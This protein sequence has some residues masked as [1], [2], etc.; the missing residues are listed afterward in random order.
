MDFEKYK[1]I[2]AI[3]FSTLKHIFRSY[4]S[5]LYQKDLITETTDACLLG[6][7]LHEKILENIDII[8]EN[9]ISIVGKRGGIL[10][11]AEALLD[12]YYGVTK[13]APLYDFS[14]MTVEQSYTFTYKDL[15]FKCRIDAYDADT[16]TLVDLKSTRKYVGFNYEFKKMYYDMQ[17]AIYTE[18][19]RANGF[20]VNNWLS[21][22]VATDAPYEHKIF[23]IDDNYILR[24]KMLLDRAIELYRNEGKDEYIEHVS[25]SPYD[26]KTLIEQGY[27]NEA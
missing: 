5:Y 27:L 2:D 23:Q 7:L 10:K 20:E 13:K 4:E 8:P 15:L 6:R 3:N 12:A 22:V 17:L 21:Y 24:G 9:H 19:L 25:L 16:K 1:E 11:S 14:T 18:G 26:T